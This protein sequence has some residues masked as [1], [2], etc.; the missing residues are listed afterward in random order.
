[1]PQFLEQACVHRGVERLALVGMDHSHGQSFIRLRVPF[2]FIRNIF[3][4]PLSNT[5]S[6]V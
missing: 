5:S 2:G 6:T 4:S 3:V 1:V